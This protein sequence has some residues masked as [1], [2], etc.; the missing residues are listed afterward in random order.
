M[1][2]LILVL[3][4]MCGVVASTERQCLVPTTRV[5]SCA[6]YFN[7]FALLIN[8][9]FCLAS[10]SHLEWTRS[11]ELMRSQHLKMKNA[12]NHQ[13]FTLLDFHLI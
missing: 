6:L 12:D 3:G 2:G 1:L 5:Q 10:Q 8:L 7:F 13:Y 11:N 4:F 9:T